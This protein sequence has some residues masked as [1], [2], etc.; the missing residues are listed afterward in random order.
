MFGNV[1]DWRGLAFAYNTFRAPTGLFQCTYKAW[2]TVDR[3]PRRKQPLFTVRGCLVKNVWQDPRR[4]RCGT[5]KW[6]IGAGEP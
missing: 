1:L 6:M 3:Q 4:D 5:D 2:H